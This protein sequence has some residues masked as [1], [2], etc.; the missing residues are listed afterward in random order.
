MLLMVYFRTISFVIS[1]VVLLAGLVISIHIR[2][3][4]E[5]SSPFECGFDPK[6]SARIPFSTR[7]FLL[8]VVFL[9][10]DI[11]IGIIMPL[12]LIIRSSIIYE[13]LLGGSFFLIILLGGLLHEWREGSLD[14]KE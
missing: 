5:K 12:P 13:V 7:F 8:A 4:R 2:E 6:A 11:E 14:W 3:D 9:V 1:I 10:F